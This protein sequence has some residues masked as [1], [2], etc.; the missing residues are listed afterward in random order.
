MP[1]YVKNSIQMKGITSL[2][3]FSTDKNGELFFDF[4]KIIKE[5]KAL[6]AVDEGSMTNIAI[7]YYLMT[8]K[9]MLFD[10]VSKDEKQLLEE[11]IGNEEAQKEIYERAKQVNGKG[12]Y[13]NVDLYAVGK[14]YVNNY[15][16]YGA[17][18][19]Y[20]WRI[21][22]WGVKWNASDYRKEND[23]KIHFT[24]AWDMPE[25]I[26]KRL[27]KKYP[28]VE[29]SCM[30]ADEDVGANAGACIYKNGKCISGGF[31]EN[32]SDTAY[33]IYVSLWG[34]TSELYKDEKGHYQYRASE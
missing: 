17:T 13:E 11:L 3:L 30:W 33:E 10:T 27:S 21:Q 24:T 26:L 22:K 29:I 18:T 23:D 6:L 8:P 20:Q 1:N 2:P 12:L 4:N 28:D 34:E 5:P 32:R 31:A 19:W 14:R 16:K 7:A 25:P 9:S 15:K